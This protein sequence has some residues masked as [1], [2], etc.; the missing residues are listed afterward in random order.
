M[1]SSPWRIISAWWKRP[2]EETLKPSTKPHGNWTGRLS[3]SDK[4]VAPPATTDFGILFLST[5]GLYAEAMRRPGLAECVWQLILAHFG[6]L[7]WPTP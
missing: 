4:Y 1:Q 7:I 2:K 3:F 6:I 5:E